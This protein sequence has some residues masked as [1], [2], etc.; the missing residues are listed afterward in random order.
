MTAL[1][2]LTLAHA[3]TVEVALDVEDAGVLTR[4]QV[5]SVAWHALSRDVGHDAVFVEAHGPAVPGIE[6]WTMR[7][8]WDPQVIKVDGHIFATLA[9]RLRIDDGSGERQWLGTALVFDHPE[10]GWVSLPDAA[11]MRTFDRAR[12]KLAEA[13]WHAL[14]ET[15]ALRVVVA[16]DEEFRADWGEHWID[17]V[18]AR[19]DRA[20]A[21]LERAGIALTVTGYEAV[22]S[23]DAADMRAMLRSLDRLELPDRAD[24]R[25]GMTGQ[26]RA[27]SA[28]DMED[29]AVAFVPGQ[30]LLIAD[31]RPALRSLASWDA[32]EEGTAMAHEVLHALG[33]PHL[34]VPGQL[35]SPE[36]AGIVHSLSPVAAT[37]ARGAME[38]RSTLDP[39][40]ALLALE[41]SARQLSDRRD[42]ISF[43][44][45]NMQAGIGVPYPGLVDP[46]RLTP[47]G[48]AALGRY[49]LR[50][51]RN[52][53]TD[54][55][56]YRR[57]A[58]LHSR[59]ALARLDPRDE[60]GSLLDEF[61]SALCDES[62]WHDAEG[63]AV[64]AD[65][66][67]VRRVENPPR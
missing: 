54:A 49:Y 39:M 65:A 24:L 32:T 46:D 6:Q 67:A 8:S 38:A 19:I 64:C 14:P 13:T 56:R 25:I 28:T 36:K 26:V 43:I 18:H 60:W 22:D 40:R 1:L 59:A 31:Q 9:P 55:D 12:G 5:E 20:N 66:P 50:Q 11:L 41:D 63:R 4:S 7:V 47:L 35:M 44:T 61:A 2:A 48:N 30:T 17:A 62:P 21:V 27:L 15:H 58:A 42:A 29:V 51:A 33:V 34:A 37:L 57:T 10:H 23:D 3:A 53:P 52:S 16:V 45:H